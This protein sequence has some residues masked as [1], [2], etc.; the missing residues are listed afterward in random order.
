MR[1]FPL[2]QLVLRADNRPWVVLL[3]YETTRREHESKQA[4]YLGEFLVSANSTTNFPSTERSHASPAT[5]ASLHTPSPS[6]NGNGSR[7]FQAAAEQLRALTSARSAVILDLRSFHHLASNQQIG[8]SNT[9]ISFTDGMSGSFASRAAAASQ[10]CLL[11]AAGDTIDW[12]DMVLREE[13]QAALSR[14]VRESLDLFKSVRRFIFASPRSQAHFQYST[15]WRNSF[16][17]WN[18]RQSVR[19][20]STGRHGGV[21]SRSRIR[22]RWIRRLVP[23]HH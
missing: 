12:D 19:C 6:E 9:Q 11:G 15:V 2:T 17:I 8:A 22:L 18:E 13:G 21:L 5:T 3:G 7:L 1:S 20:D 16:R 14:A 23:C 10:I 4:K